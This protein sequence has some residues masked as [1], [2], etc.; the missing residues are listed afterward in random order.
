MDTPDILAILFG[1]IAPIGV[2]GGVVNRVQLKK[3]IGVQFIRYNT[4]IVA[5]PI[6]A[7]L[8]LLGMLT[9]AVVSLLAGALGY[10]FA[11][12]AGGEK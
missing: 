7:S 9:E 4:V 12:F 2:I 3:G 11:G 6:A 10:A 8:A 5:L 1:M